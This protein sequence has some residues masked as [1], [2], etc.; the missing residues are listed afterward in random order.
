M[1]TRVV[2]REGHLA[3]GGEALELELGAERGRVHA[4]K[5]S[6]AAP[7]LQCLIGG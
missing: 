2:R 1:M 4:E 5:V 3:D 7:M 6:A